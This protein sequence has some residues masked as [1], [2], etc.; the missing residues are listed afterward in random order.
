MA[1]ALEG[2]KVIDCSQVAAVPMAARH[3]GDFGADVIH[4][5]HPVTGDFWRGFQEAQAESG[6][7][8]SSDFNYGWEQF[9][10]NKRSITLNLYNENGRAIMHKM[11]AQADVF[12]SNLRPF[13]LEK[14]EM[15]YETLSK[16]NPRLI[17]GN[18]NGY[19]KK[20]PEKDNPAYDT[21]A[22]WARAGIHALFSMPGAPV[23]TYRPAFGDTVAGLALAYGVVQALYVRE[24]T[25]IGQAVDISLLHTGL[26]QLS[27]DVS[28][29]L[30][31]GKDIKDWREEPSLEMQQQSLA[32][33]AQI[34]DFYAAR[35]KS[36]LT[37]SYLT[38]DLRSLLFIVLQ[39]D[40]YWAKFCKAV[41]RE[42]LAQNPKYDTIEGRAEDR[43]ALRKTFAEIF[44]T[45]TLAE[46]IPLLE[47]IPY[48]PVQTILEAVHDV[49]ARENG[50]FVSYEHPER[51][52]IEQLANP[53]MMSRTPA[54][55][56]LPAPEF[57]QHT[58]E[59]LLEHGYTWEDIS[60]FQKDGT[61]A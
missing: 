11:A 36:P 43:I 24:K 48:A 28:G 13:E 51:G 17:W 46:W 58:E 2:I 32:A 57:G 21:T 18:I 35:T 22:Y 19:G 6:G 39:P 52:M 59:V 27:F 44:I 49:Q 30:A 31:T 5:E 12:V 56:R 38:Q 25:G 54:S 33:I 10:R 41:G 45:K 61:I 55:V 1:M 37:G 4:V 9:N 26:Y 29:A 3:L 50:Y 40:R 23:L 16:I 15:D 34:A 60:V 8:I 14:F 7:G 47:G 20:G 42:D 53:V